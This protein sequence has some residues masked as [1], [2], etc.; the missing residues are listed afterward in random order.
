M[1]WNIRV[2]L[3]IVGGIVIALDGEMGARIDNAPDPVFD[4]GPHRIVTPPRTHIKRELS[5]VS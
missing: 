4:S 1:R 5:I 3:V 2:N